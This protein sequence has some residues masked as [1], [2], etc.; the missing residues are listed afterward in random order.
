MLPDANKELRQWPNLPAD[1]S[2]TINS[3]VKP[4]C[5]QKVLPEADKELWEYSEHQLKVNIGIQH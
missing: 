1:G 4:C 3:T 2:N 5:A